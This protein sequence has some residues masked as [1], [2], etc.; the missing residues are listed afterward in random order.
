ML[1]DTEVV[2][3]L[4]QRLPAPLCAD[5]LARLLR[6]PSIWNA[7]HQPE[8]LAQIVEAE[9]IEALRPADILTARIRPRRPTEEAL[10]QILEG[11]AEPDPDEP[12]LERLSALCQVI[13]WT[14]QRGVPCAWAPRLAD[15]PVWRDALACAWPDMADTAEWLQAAFTAGDRA[16]QEAAINALLANAAPQDAA[17]LL[18]RALGDALGAAISCLDQMGESPLATALVVS[19][20]PHGSSPK[21]LPQAIAAATSARFR[22]EVQGGQLA[23]QQAWDLAQ[24][25]AADVADR[26]ADFAEDH[27]ELVLGAEARQRAL[28]ASAS[29]RRRAALAW[30]QIRLAKLDQA[31]N[32]LAQNPESL[33]ECLV[34]ATALLRQ[35]EREAAERLLAE[36]PVDP[37]Q[38]AEIPWV[39]LE[40]GRQVAG[41]LGSLR[42]VG[43]ISEEIARRMPASAE[44][45]LDRAK[46]FTSTGQPEQAVEAASVAFAL[47][48]ATAEAEQVLARALVAAGRA[49]LALPIWKRLAQT[50]PRSLPD[51]A[52]CALQ[53]GDPALAHQLAEQIQADE[54]HSLAAAI[55]KARAAAA[56]GEIE[57]ARRQLHHLVTT[58]PDAPAAWIALADL[59]SASGE[60][61]LAGATL[62][63]AVQA[64]PDT[65]LLLMAYARWLGGHGR[66]TEAAAHAIRAVATDQ[67]PGDWLRQT[68]E[69]LQELGRPDEAILM[70]R[71]AAD[72]LPHDAVIQNTLAEAL[73]AAGDVSGAYRC[74]HSLPGDAKG[75]DH[76]LAG[77]VAVSLAEQ[78][79][80]PAALAWA[81]KHLAAALSQGTGATEA[82]LWYAQAQLRSGNAIA[83]A[84]HYLAA[85]AKAAP[86]TPT[87]SQ[88]ALAL[89]D[90]ALEAGEPIIALDPLEALL[91]LEPN[92]VP[93]HHQLAR[94]YA[95]CAMWDKAL[96]LAERAASLA[97]ADPLAW[98]R[99]GDIAAAAGAGHAALQAYDQLTA[100]Q[101]ADF[102]AWLALADSAARL[103]R[104]DIQRLALSHA[105]RLGR[106]NTDSLLRLS[107]ILA[108]MG[109]TSLAML[110]LRRAHSV[111]SRDTAPLLALAQI[112]EL[113]GDRHQAGLAWSKLTE[114]E[115]TNVEF[116]L[117]TGQAEHAN[118]RLDD[119]VD[120]YR[121]ATI[122]AP[123]QPR[124]SLALARELWFS[125]E[126]S[127]AEQEYRHALAAFP[128]DPLV[129][130]A[131]AQAFLAMGRVDEALQVSENAVQQAP[132]EPQALLCLAECLLRSA[133]PARLLALLDSPAADTFPVIALACLRTL[134]HLQLG[135]PEGASF[136]FA[137]A[138][139]PQDPSPSDTLWI[140]RA[141]RELGAWAHV[142]RPSQIAPAALEEEQL[143]AMTGMLRLADASW[144][145]GF[146]GAVR[147][148]PSAEWLDIQAWDE[149]SRLEAALSQFPA[150]ADHSAALARRAD[151]YRLANDDQRRTAL[152]QLL[153][154]QP[155]ASTA[156]TLG[157]AC[158]RAGLPADALAALRTLPE[159]G[160][161]WVDLL[162]GMAH[163]GQGAPALA[164]D[165]FHAAAASPALRPLVAILRGRTYLLLGQED[166]GLSEFSLALAAWPDEAAWHAELASAYAET[167]DAQRAL[168]HLQQAVALA[169]E[170]QDYHL[171]YARAL[172]DAGQAMEAVQEYQPVLESMPRVGGVWKEAGNAALAAGANSIAQSWFD[173]ACVLLPDE[174]QVW[175][176]AALAAHREGN[177]RRA[178]ELI[179]TA[180]R[181]EPENVKVLMAQGE[182]FAAAGKHDKALQAYNAALVGLDDPLPAHLGRVGVMSRIGRNAEAIA[183]IERLQIEHADDERLWLA[184]S[185]ACEGNGDLPGALAAAE[186]AVE[187][188]PRLPAA[189]VA[190]GRLARKHGQLDRAIDV[191][192]TFAPAGAE[193]AIEL[194]MAYEARRE[195]G[196]ALEQ[197]QRAIALDPGSAAAHFHAGAVLRS[198]KDYPQASRMFERAVEL[199][200]KDA[201][202]LH[203]LAAVRTL[204]LVHGAIPLQ[205]VMQ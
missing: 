20:T 153:A 6:V 107:G 75:I 172:V 196:R 39:W 117:A 205:A 71:R 175:V 116:L 36:L 187:L 44:A 125:G 74:L 92:S 52:D 122:A 119:A 72:M 154:R 99:L 178:T 192:T 118:G 156:E 123:E 141:A 46:F 64:V 50:D 131:A 26:L 105:L 126:P 199:D 15:D 150:Y 18:R 80:E 73:E 82:E 113:C 11:S 160:S 49:P 41:A 12:P 101:P 155:A 90:A 53:A 121:R 54:P 79:G 21:D 102:E 177:L 191:L 25:A 186:K 158:L 17:D 89:A 135:E 142:L 197:F 35:G 13:L 140:S 114:L 37:R 67:A 161:P 2:A 81:V 133:Q 138:T 204:E 136:A 9:S 32:T 143:E 23:L 70:L 65:P 83:A 124:P 152:R 69:W 104:K 179:Q 198:I 165:C 194:G 146:V 181:L 109:E 43:Q 4:G 22:G 203:Q 85:T 182:I 166:P 78:T 31:L 56:L 120:L 8:V 10:L 16:L 100:L 87:Y 190:L 19:Q 77:R 202:A 176:G 180:S 200:P 84:Q 91:A 58:N 129:L 147:H 98:R 97:P 112:A 188:A 1:N 24:A 88:A 59:Q 40:R 127:G 94:V 115:P 106:R 68:G 48:P 169:P 111:D 86:G 149:W 63:A 93:A 139:L 27:D 173:Q 110:T 30:C 55:L 7:L 184:L 96:P 42:L 128:H 189:R 157:I 61:A 76:L 60:E 168:P 57:T 62:A 66:T 130:L 5:L 185:Q 34:R 28:S 103:E 159:P 108:S 162:Q 148:A 51:F 164:L 47:Q 134:A 163:A 170:V 145:Y 183:E 137:Q 167:S 171:A 33:E 14:C 151:L 45:W 174:A 95:A 3:A 201:D 193:A 132:S 29:P 195:Y 144:L 38:L